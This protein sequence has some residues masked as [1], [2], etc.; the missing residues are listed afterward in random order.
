MATPCARRGFK[1]V[2]SRRLTAGGK[3]NGSTKYDV[4]KSSIRVNSRSCIS[5]SSSDSEYRPEN[6]SAENSFLYVIPEIRPRSRSREVRV[7]VGNPSTPFLLYI[8]VH[9]DDFTSTSNGLTPGALTA[10]RCHPQ[11]PTREE[12][13]IL[14]KDFPYG[15][16]YCNAACTGSYYMTYPNDYPLFKELYR[17]TP[18]AVLFGSIPP[19][20]LTVACLPYFISLFRYLVYYTA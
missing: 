18:S 8:A 20:G 5:S 1:T 6:D 11:I 9:N 12:I 17:N 2:E 14:H 19:M 15:I 7:R 10:H 3:R 16:G 13:F 4:T